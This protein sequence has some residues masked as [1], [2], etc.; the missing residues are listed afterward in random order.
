MA[1]YVNDLRLKE[2]ATGDESGTWGTSTNTNLELIGEALG[3]GTQD[4]F[5]SDANATTTVADAASDPARAMYFKVTSSATLSATRTLTIAPNTISRVMF[6]ENATTGSQSITISQGSGANVTILTGKTAIVYLDG[7]GSGA[8]VVD[9]MALIDPGVTDTLTEVLAAG[10]AT[11]GTDIATTTTDKIQFRDAAIYINSSVDGQLDIVAD[12]EIQIAATTV[13]LNGNL[14]VSG[15]ALVTG[16]LTT[17]ATQVATGGITSGSSILS[18]TDSTD[19]LGSTGVR[20]LK[21]WF[22]TL[23]AG[24]LTIGSGSVTDSSGSISFGNENLSTTGTATAASL[25]LATGATVTG[26]DNGALGTSATLLATQG[27]IKTYVDAQVGTVDTLAEILANGNTTGGTDLVVSAGDV[28]S[29]DDTTDTTSTTT[30]SIHTDGGLGVAKKSYLGNTVTIDQNDNAIALSIDSESTATSV[31]DIADATTTGTII[32]TQAHSLTSGRIANFYSASSDS[33]TRQL[34]QIFNDHTS[35]SGTTALQVRQDAAQDALFIDQNGNG[36]AFEIDTESTSQNVVVIDQ[37]ATTTAN[38]L[39]IQNADTLTTGRLAYLHSN[40]ADTSTRNLVQIHND[41]ALATGAK[42]LNVRQDAAQDALFI[43]QNG[44]SVALDIDT[45]ATSAGE[46]INI[47]L[48]QQTA[49]DVLRVYGADSLTTG[50]VASFHSNSA[51]TSTRNLVEMTNDNTAATGATVLKIQQDA[52]Q[53]ALAIDQN[54]NAAGLY[55]DT[56]ATT[57]AGINIVSPAQTTGR[58]IDLSGADSLT[59]GYM[60]VADSN[61]AS[62]SSRTLVRFANENA[63]AVNTT[64]LEV[65]SAA[66]M[67]LL[68]DQNGNEKAISIQSESTTSDILKVNANALTTGRALDVVVSP[69]SGFTT[70]SIARFYSGSS[71]SGTKNLVEMTN[72]NAAASGSTVLNIQQDAAQTGLFIDQNGNGDALSIDTEAT[73]QDGILVRAQALTTGSAIAITDV[74]ALTT[75]SIGW[76]HSSSSTT[77]TRSLVKIHNDHASATGTTSLEVVQ[78][79]AQKALFIDQNGNARALDIDSEATTAFSVA[80]NSD[81][82]TTGVGIFATADSLTTGNVAHF[83]S[84]SADTG[85]RDVVFIHNDNALATG[86]TALKVTQDAAQTGLF[87]D[88]N[89]NGVGMYID[90]EATTANVITAANTVT[91]GS[92]FVASSSDSLTTGAIGYFRSNSA[93]TSTRQLVRIINDNALATGAT[94][95]RIQQDSTAP[96]AILDKGTTDGGFV[97]WTATADGDTTSAISTLTTSGATT[98]H[99]QVEINGTKAWIAVSTNNPS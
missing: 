68:V 17:T 24:T 21:G 16:V 90:S 45:E 29:I 46:A 10:N 98:H 56:E 11:G 63:L 96:A 67:G 30:G 84:I 65:E 72:D 26:I 47:S 18:D 69:G 28:L 75:G 50:S 52:A 82:T 9:A 48:P 25:A 97:D 40:S 33:S 19:S 23:A 42:S 6:I 2:I 4:C 51:S 37:P 12:T 74:N 5:S 77:D 3:Y 79:A 31:I 14:D 22:D 43:D 38:G 99:I 81:Q 34:V 70:G 55:I 78:D 62:T 7:A 54:G 93:N 61:S 13:D 36:V 49:A 39:A 85:A 76:F 91:S 95:L 60:I 53:N 8:A 80:L 89:G 83:V 64:V 66:G 15:T 88:Q 35:A 20:W 44:N 92:V 57:A 86:A 27:A 94:G 87:I 32:N 59:S 73:T 1:T 41:N 58:V 71:D